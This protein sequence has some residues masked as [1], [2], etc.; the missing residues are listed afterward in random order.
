MTNYFN[1]FIYVIRKDPKVRNKII[2][3]LDRYNKVP[4]NYQSRIRYDILIRNVILKKL[5]KIKGITITDLD[6]ELKMKLSRI[7]DLENKSIQRKHI[8]SG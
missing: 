4:Y 2:D 8:V 1:D 6:I 5:I 7:N 3:M